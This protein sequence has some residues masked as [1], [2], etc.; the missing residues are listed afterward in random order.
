MDLITQPQALAWLAERDLVEDPCRQAPPGFAY[1][2]LVLPEGGIRADQLA[3]VLI[4]RLEPAS[5]I[6]QI[7][8]WS[9]RGEEEG[10]ALL[11]EIGKTVS[12]F[13]RVWIRISEGDRRD[14]QECLSCILANGMSAY[15]YSCAPGFI[16]YFW[17]GHFLE[18]WSRTPALLDSMASSLECL[19]VVAAP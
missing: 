8:D 19:G 10:P 11:R 2:R 12:T 4:Q 3:E 1:L 15:L 18:I 17:E 9:G 7:T 6:L 14:L 5:Q 13:D 16:A